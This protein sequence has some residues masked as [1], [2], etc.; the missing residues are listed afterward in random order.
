MQAEHAG[1]TA[2]S[3]EPGRKLTG[4]QWAHRHEP[5]GVCE[6][7]ERG[8]QRHLQASWLGSQSE[9]GARVGEAKLP[10]GPPS[11]WAVSRGR[12]TGLWDS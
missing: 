7:S 6:R 8:G 10:C 5:K 12:S 1:K 9:G 11:D 2:V 4:K 3:C